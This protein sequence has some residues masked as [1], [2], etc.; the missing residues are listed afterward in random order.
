MSKKLPGKN[1]P[2]AEQWKWFETHMTPEVR[3]RL[4]NE[5]F[6]IL[7]KKED[8]EDILSHSMELGIS[9]LSRLRSE[10]KFFSWM[11]T[12]VR[13]EA[14]HYLKNEN[15]MQSVKYAFHLIK[16]YYEASAIPEKLVIAKDERERL[17][18]QIDRL[19]S[20]EKEIMLLKLRTDQSLKE[21]ADE[22]HLNYHTTRSMFTRTC[23][24][25]ARNLKKEEGDG[26]NEKV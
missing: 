15:K 8:A 21:I 16:D 19:D 17:R 26:S 3:K 25:I 2:T 7:Q 24:R 12:I 9:N 14:T 6:R 23:K 10:D 18:R 5:A 13:R 22:L 1:A 4:Y 20:P 11:F